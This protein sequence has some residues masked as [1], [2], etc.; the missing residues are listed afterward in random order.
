MK[1][2][3]LIKALSVL[4]VTLLLLVVQSFLKN[5]NCTEK[6]AQAIEAHY[7]SQERLAQYWITQDHL[8]LEVSAN[9]FGCAAARQLHQAGLPL[10]LLSKDSILYWN[11]ASVSLAE[12]YSL[13]PE[14]VHLPSG[15]HY[16]TIRHT[17]P[18]G[19][20]AVALVATKAAVSTPPSGS[21]PIHNQQGDVVFY[22]GQ[23]SLAHFITPCSIW[24]FI[25]TLCIILGFALTVDYS[26]TQLLAPHQ[27]KEVVGI[28]AVACFALISYWAGAYNTTVLATLAPHHLKGIN[29]LQWMSIAVLSIW[30]LSLLQRINRRYSNHILYPPGLIVFLIYLSI[31]LGIITLPVLIKHI[32][33]NSELNYDFQ[34]ITRLGYAEIAC[35]IAILLLLS[36]HF[37][38][39]LWTARKVHHIGI[40]RQARLLLLSFAI[41]VTIALAAILHLELN[42]LLISLVLILFA[43]LLDLFV[44]LNAGSPAWL[45]LWL[46]LLAAFTSGLFFKYQLDVAQD[47]R[48]AIAQKLSSPRDS[49]LEDIISR[50]PLSI[51]CSG[52]CG[53]LV[54]SSMLSIPYLQKNY[55]WAI[56]Y[57]RLDG[58]SV[59]Q[60]RQGQWVRQKANA[61]FIN[62]SLAIETG[63]GK[64]VY[65]HFTPK[66]H[67]SRKILDRLIPSTP[68]L[69]ADYDFAIRHEGQI[70]AQKG[71]VEKPQSGFSGL[72]PPMEYREQVSSQSASTYYSSHKEEDY[73]VAVVEKL[74]GYIKP[75]SLF[76]YL[77]ALLAIIVLLLLVINH[78]ILIFPARP[79]T[80]LF[81]KPSL[82]HRIQLATIGV[83]LAAFIFACTTTVIFLQNSWESLQSRQMIERVN[84]VLRALS[85]NADSGTIDKT[86]L[87][88]ISESQQVDISLYSSDGRLILSSFPQV[89]E[90]R[91]RS[92]LLPPEAFFALGHPSYGPNITREELLGLSCYVA[93]L[94]VKRNE[95][96]E[97]G[98]FISIT[99]SAQQ[100]ALQEKMLSFVGYLLNLYVFLLLIASATAIAIAKSITNPL[101]KLDEK[102]RAF[103]LGKNRPLEWKSQ[104]E[105][106][107]LIDAY[108]DMIKALEVSTEKL[109]QSER[110][111][112]WREMAKQVAHEIKNPLTPMK[113]SIQYLKHAQRTDPQK[114]R[115]LIEQVSKTLVEQ[116]DGLAHIATAF[117][118]FAKMPKAE[119]APTNINETL[120][121]IYQLFLPQLSGHFKLTLT[122]PEQE[123]V[124]MADQKQLLRVFNNLLKN[125]QQAI[126]HHREGDLTIRLSVEQPFAVVEV[127]DNGTGIPAEV[128]ANIFQPNFTTK[129]S[130][131]G[132][133][134][135]MCKNIVESANGS[136]YFTTSPEEGTSFFVK[137]PLHE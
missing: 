101:S 48:R 35:L 12:G 22:M 55:R 71:Y 88:Y 81:G 98:P 99:L 29:L 89:Y 3:Q 21:I 105:I 118:N 34:H 31:N 67:A 90:K 11:T 92:T 132:L 91:I 39:S 23:Q 85:P 84:T 111:N 60:P 7:Q 2:R 49:T 104:D 77:F 93:T 15:Q 82:R 80:Q 30:L 102:L 58:G 6:A 28:A 17:L 14:Q 44:E 86:Q 42:I 128:Q 115:E 103:K 36:G 62:Y 54:D 4:S 133:G 74:G 63:E 124:V 65:I 50:L 45:I 78:Y 51:S 37:F 130:G 131:M 114:A 123:V 61:Y 100:E 125:A 116:I 126:P 96:I 47:K 9:G 66:L 13:L 68:F 1:N 19:L 52:N 46:A 94:P 122:L 97:E 56:H 70:V 75:I 41:A 59:K 20:M 129:S 134:L 33:G 25:V 119:M 27:K 113:L 112:A 76:S 40:S 73:E 24:L 64:P 127:S 95:R 117:S 18:D 53:V 137:L 8:W 38:Y 120:H 108:N 110:E 121:S 72:L 83:T 16:S 135:A 79:G 43:A 10:F 107:Q 69:I 57:D 32:V 109:K 136:I 106:G 5:D 87:A 26:L